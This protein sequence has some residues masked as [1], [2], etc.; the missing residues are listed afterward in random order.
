MGRESRSG[1]GS[2]G[3]KQAK[4]KRH[5]VSLPYGGKFIGITSFPKG[6][7]LNDKS[8]ELGETFKKEV[9]PTLKG[10]L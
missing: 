4:K 10:H 7:N 2:D 1:S 8:A 9:Y 6:P 5:T 3:K